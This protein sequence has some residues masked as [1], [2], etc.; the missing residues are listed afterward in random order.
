[1]E[2]SPGPWPAPSAF[3]GPIAARRSRKKAKRNP[4]SFV[5]LVF[6][7]GALCYRINLIRVHT[8]A[9]DLAGETFRRSSHL[10]VLHPTK[11]SANNPPASI[12]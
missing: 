10:L 2:P 5:G 11:R 9:G 12:N 7:D 6:Y 3:A 4:A 1:M 8:K